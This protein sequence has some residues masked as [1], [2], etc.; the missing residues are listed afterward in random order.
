MVAKI[1][2]KL[3]KVWNIIRGLDKNW[4]GKVDIDDKMI[5]AQEAAKEKLGE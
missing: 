2:S 3:L 4:D 5:E 1:K